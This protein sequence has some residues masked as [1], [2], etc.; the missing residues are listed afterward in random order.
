MAKKR[1][2][3]RF[4]E[5]LID[6][7]TNEGYA[8]I[9]QAYYTREF[10]NRTFNLHDSYGSAVYYNGKLI[11][12]TIRYVGQEHYTTGKF[13]GWE[14]TKSRSVPNFRGIRFYTG[15]QVDMTGRE[16][17]MDFFSQYTPP[18]KGLQLVVVAAMWYGL[19]LEK[20][21]GNLKRKYRVISGARTIMDELAAKY[22]GSV[23]QIETGR[24]L[25]QQHTFKGSSWKQ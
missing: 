25:T 17:V 10:T 5:E 8:A 21:G 11:K 12:R 3:S 13:Y 22:G 24:V 6:E 16:E 2:Q 4:V 7:L 23:S 1:V 15:D 18:N 9:L 20:G 14:W 19:I